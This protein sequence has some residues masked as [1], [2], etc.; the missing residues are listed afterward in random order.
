MK[1][2]GL[3][4]GLSLMT[5]VAVAEPA[6]FGLEMG[7]ATVDDLKAKYSAELT[8]VNK[9]SLGPMYQ[10]R[11]GQLGVSGLQKATAIFDSGNKLV[12]VLTEMPKSKFDQMHQALSSKYRVVSKQIPFVGNKKVVMEDGET[13]ITLDAPHMSFEM[14]MNYINKSFYESFRRISEEEKRQK[15]Q[16]EMGNL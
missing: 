11:P 13:E 14:E 10:L 12:A 5:A 6:P 16:Q 7:K 1:K 15:R 9:Y 3:F 2:L 4:F 8:G